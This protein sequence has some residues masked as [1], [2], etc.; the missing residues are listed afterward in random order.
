MWSQQFRIKLKLIVMKAQRKVIF[1]I[2]HVQS[3]LKM[4]SQLKK[5]QLTAVEK[6]GV[7]ARRNE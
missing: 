7:E 3:N 2:R 4:K 6:K 5:M 1:I